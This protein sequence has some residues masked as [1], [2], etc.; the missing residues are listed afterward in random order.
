[1]VEELVQ[2]FISVVYTKLLK[3]VFLAAKVFETKNIQNAKKASVLSHVV[4]PGAGAA[5]DK[6][7]DPRKAS[8]VERLGDRMTILLSLSVRIHEQI[9]MICCGFLHILG[10]RKSSGQEH[11]LQSFLTH[12]PIDTPL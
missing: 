3:T 4:C 12:G 7:D 11:K 6:V 1:M 10:L 8:T 2:F 9:T 5:I